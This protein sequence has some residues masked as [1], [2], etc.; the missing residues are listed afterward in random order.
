MAYA[1]KE[2]SKKQQALS[3]SS[4]VR[5]QNAVDVVKDSLTNESTDIF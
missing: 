3:K 4:V 5:V 1:V 2:N